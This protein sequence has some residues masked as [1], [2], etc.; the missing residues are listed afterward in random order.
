MKPD[1]RRKILQL[2]ES[3]TNLR[4]DIDDETKQFMVDEISRYDLIMWPQNVAMEI[5][6][7]M[8]GG[9]LTR[10]QLS[11]VLLFAKTAKSSRKI[12]FGGIKIRAKLREI[13][14]IKS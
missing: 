12:E 4:K 10:P 9:E 6:R 14:I 8:I 7:A 1:Q 13:V 5:L 2:Y 11:Q 3:Q